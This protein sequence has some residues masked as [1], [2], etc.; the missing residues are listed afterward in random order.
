MSPGPTTTAPKPWSAL[1][2]VLCAALGAHA[3][4][5]TLTRLP[6]ATTGAAAFVDFPSA[7]LTFPAGTHGLLLMQGVLTSTATTG[8][9]ELELFD[10][11]TGFIYARAGAEATALGTRRSWC[12]FDFLD[13][14][15]ATQLQGRLRHTLGVSSTSEALDVALLALPPSA[16]A[17][18]GRAEPA[19][20]TVA[21]GRVSVLDVALPSS[22]RQTLHLAG[23]EVRKPPTALNVFAESND[24]LLGQAPMARPAADPR[25][26]LHL[27]DAWAPMVSLDLIAAPS[28]HVTS[29]V[30]GHNLD[31]SYQSTSMEP[32]EYAS[33]RVVTFDL[34]S[35]SGSSASGG[36]FSV[37]SPGT[38]TVAAS[39]SLGG[40][41]GQPVLVLFG[42]SSETTGV[43]S[44]M[45]FEVERVPRF[46]TVNFVPA[47][48]RLSNVG[49]ALVDPPGPFFS[50]TLSAVGGTDEVT[51]WN[52]VLITLGPF[53]AGALDAGSDGDAGRPGDAGLASDAGV[54]ADAGAP[55]AGGPVDAGESIE[56]PK[57][58]ALQVGCGCAAGDV[59]WAWWVLAIPLGRWARRSATSRR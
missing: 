48:E 33:A 7:P 24:T 15:V 39:V 8:V 21:G 14:P 18:A 41:P 52:P 22:A 11:T 34:P 42:G 54:S 30:V 56:R 13:R 29:V 37:A 27:S 4:S 26:F 36:M 28:P 44:R 32:A 51:V 31:G 17:A 25:N 10:P 5:L 59:S 23:V 16:G 9:V 1:P 58:L 45:R 38:S 19:A 35:V 3:E 43:V 40:T 2:L 55:D 12:F 57:P 47:G 49:F 20:F 53:D 46:E 50:M 6:D